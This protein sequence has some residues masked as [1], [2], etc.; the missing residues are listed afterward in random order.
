MR[1][2]S[3]ELFRSVDRDRKGYLDIHD[4]RAF[5]PKETALQSIQTLLPAL[6]LQGQGEWEE[7]GAGCAAAKKDLGAA[8]P[9]A[10]PDADVRRARA[11]GGGAAELRAQMGA[12]EGVKKAKKKVKK[13]EKGLSKEKENGQAEGGG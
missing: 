2:K 11:W 4:F 10:L 13:G 8:P 12:G 5:F 1:L 7:G 3:K 9:A 6:C